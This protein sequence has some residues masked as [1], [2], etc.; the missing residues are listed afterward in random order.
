[1]CKI[2][3]QHLEHVIIKILGPQTGTGHVLHLVLREGEGHSLLV[4]VWLDLV[5]LHHARPSV[6][7]PIVWEVSSFSAS[8]TLNYESY[9][10]SG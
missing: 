7:V 5:P 9:F 4:H 2:V 1:M 8:A 3:W 10:K 6:V